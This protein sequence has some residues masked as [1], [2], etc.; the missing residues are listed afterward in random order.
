MSPLRR[1]L[2][3][4]ATFIIIATILGSIVYHNY[5]KINT[6][7]T[8]MVMSR[9]A[10][11]AE[12]LEQGVVSRLDALRS[13]AGSFS[14]NQDVANAVRTGKWEVAIQKIQELE[15]IPVYS[16]R[17]IDRIV[18]IDGS[19][20]SRAD[21]PALDGQLGKNLST[22]PWFQE[23]QKGKDSVVSGN[24]KR[25]AIPQINIV[26]VA[27]AIRDA[28]GELKGAVVLQVPA[29]RFS[30]LTNQ[31]SLSERG[32]AYLTDD[33]G[34]IVA[35]PKYTDESEVVDFSGVASVQKALGGGSG[36]E[37][38]YNPIEDELR[39]AAYAQVKGYGWGVVVVEPSASA[40]AERNAI[41]R[42]L[43]YIFVGCMVIAFVVA[44]L[45]FRYLGAAKFKIRKPSLQKGFTLIELLVVIAIVA[46]LAVVVILTLNPA[47]LIRQAR[48]SNRLSD[49]STL[50][51]AIG[52]YMVD[53]TSPNLASTTLGYTACYVST[54]SGTG[55]TTAKCGLFSGS[56]IT[57]ISSSSAANYLKVDGTG[58]LP[59]VLSSLSVGAPIG[60]LPVDP[61]NSAAYFYA[62][63]ASASPMTFELDAFL[64]STKYRATFPVNDGGNRAD[65]YEVGSAPGLSL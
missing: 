58:W 31:I 62:Y 3:S 44:I 46:V 51:T 16:D 10:G 1:W 8:D 29:D 24:Y 49:L 57:A 38:L 35:H 11:L 22:R 47:E 45:V 43:V 37:E 28:K 17:F 64:E 60:S 13:L 21:F 23:L 9:R 52:L 36:V 6:E 55:T 39:V 33:L 56:G 18:V 63:A 25:A 65:V 61:L 27:S 40:F 34:H 20:V 12:M 59:V 19:G 30:N 26:A 50:R 4:I 2:L 15:K 32:F 14:S 53:N 5:Q 41:L 42:Q 54:P 7:L 48:D